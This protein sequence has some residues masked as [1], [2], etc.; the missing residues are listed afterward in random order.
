[1]YLQASPE[2]EIFLPE[3]PERW[4]YRCAPLHLAQIIP[5]KLSSIF[6]AKNVLILPF[7]NLSSFPPLSNS[8]VLNVVLALIQ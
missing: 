6:C 8:S 5:L 4:N 7:W 2:L 3:P 1:M